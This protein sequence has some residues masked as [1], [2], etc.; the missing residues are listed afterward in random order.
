MYLVAMQIYKGCAIEATAKMCSAD[1]SM[2]ISLGP[3][4]ILLV[5]WQLFDS[6]LWRGVPASS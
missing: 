3:F 4:R 2:L 1:C 5:A 6:N